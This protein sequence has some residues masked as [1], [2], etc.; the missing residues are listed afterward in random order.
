M[1]SGQIYI[2]EYVALQMRQNYQARSSKGQSKI[3]YGRDLF[4]TGKNYANIHLFDP[5]WYM[6]ILLTLEPI[7]NFSGR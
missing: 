5:E 6:K 2:P 3:L 1:D 7:I 4:V